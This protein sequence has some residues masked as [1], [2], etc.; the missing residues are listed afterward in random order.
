MAKQNVIEKL[1]AWFQKYLSYGNTATPYVVA[2]WVA[3]THVFEMFDSFPY[4]V[5]TARV[6]RAGKTRQSECISFT[7]NMP[8][9]VS[10]AT[11]AALYR[12]LEDDKPTLLWDEA[13]TLNSESASIVRAFLNVG[14][15]KGQT[16]PRAT[17]DGVK[18]WPTYCPKVF[19]LIGDVYDTLRDRS[20]IIEMQRGESPERFMYERAKEEG[21]EIHDE[22][23]AALLE[24]TEEIQRQYETINLPFLSDRDEEIWRP[25]FAIARALKLDITKL[26]MAAADMY[27][28]KTAPRRAH[29]DKEMQAA[30][31]ANER[32]KEF[33]LLLI[34]DLLSLIGKNEKGIYTADALKKLHAIPTAPW[35]KYL[36]EG[37]TADHMGMLAARYKVTPKPI[38]LGNTIARG[39]GQGIRRGYLK[40]DLQRAVAEAT[41]KDAR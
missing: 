41:G 33:G 8:A 29:N 7:C 38:R 40:T 2:L 35:R 20:I 25:L 31:E 4:L 16:I 13:E 30:E 11:A 24:V 21:L 10:G 15:R 17:A 37:L 14:Y 36:G 6:K 28:E 19:T 32:I 26:E 9:T 39:K 27:A 23:R 18:Q 5:I 22:L 34:Q 12:M 3:A 1:A